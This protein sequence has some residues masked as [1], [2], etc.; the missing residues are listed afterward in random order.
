METKQ[1]IFDQLISQ[2]LPMLRNT[3]YGILG[4]AADADD[5]VQN[6]LVKAWKKFSIFQSRSKLSSWVCRITINTAY[7]MIRQ[8]QREA[9]KLQHYSPEPRQEQDDSKLEALEQAIAELPE[10]YRSALTLTCFGG[11][12]GNEAAELLGCSTNTLYWRI[13]HAKVLLRCKMKGI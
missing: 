5:A 7:D 2:S 3:A 4:N 12:S 13:N 11:V 9:E 1:A 6:A 10:L 8:K